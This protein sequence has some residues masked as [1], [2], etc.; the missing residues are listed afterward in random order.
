MRLMAMLVVSVFFGL[1]ACAATQTA[2]FAGGCFWSMQKVFEPLLS[3]GIVKTT[4]GFAGGKKTSPTYDEVVSGSTGHYEAVEVVYDPGKISYEKILDVYWKN[5]DPYDKDGQ[6]CD[7]GEQ[8]RTAIFATDK[9]R[10]VAQASKEKLV[11]SGTLKGTIATEIRAAEKFYAAEDYHQR[12]YAKNP[13]RYES[14]RLGCGRD[15][16]VREI[17]G[18]GVKAP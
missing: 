9:Q 4:V 7:K 14:Y 3:Q 2:V 10:K 11:K 15:R 8:Y 13:V 18:E 5:I 12:F 16:R 17:W 1:P 6:F